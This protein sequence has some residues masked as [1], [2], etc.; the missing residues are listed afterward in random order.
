LGNQETFLVFSSHTNQAF[1]LENIFNFSEKISSQRFNR[2][3]NLM[4]NYDYKTGHYLGSWDKLHPQL[5]VSFI[6]VSRGIRKPT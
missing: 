3:L 6:E 4:I 2:F 1:R 5:I